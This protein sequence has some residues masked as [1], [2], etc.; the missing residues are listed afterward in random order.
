MLNPN[1]LLELLQTAPG[2]RTAVILPEAGLRVTYQSLRDQVNGMADT[3][4]ALGVQRGDRVATVLP[5]GLLKLDDLQLDQTSGYR[6]LDRIVYDALLQWEFEPLAPQMPQVDQ[7][8]LITFTF[9][10]NP[11]P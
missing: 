10:F 6:E 4:A 1:T 11:V 7:S 5:N 2:G 9:S 8:G 3:L